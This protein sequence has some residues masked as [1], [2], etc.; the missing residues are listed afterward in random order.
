MRLPSF[1]TASLYGGAALLVGVFF[2]FGCSGCGKDVKRLNGGGATF[3]DPIM[4]KWSAVYKEQKGVEI[5]YKKSGSGNGIQQMI[6]KTIDFGCTDAPMNAEQLDTAKKEGGDVIHVPVIVGS[7]AVIYNLPEAGDRQLILSGKVIAKIYQGIADGDG[8]KAVRWNDPEI[9]ALNPGVNFPNKEIVPVYRS[10]SSGTTKIFTEYLSKSSTEFAQK[11]GSS[12]EPKWPK[13]GS[14]QNGNDGV[15]R[16]VKESANAIGYVELFYAQKNEIRF[17]KV[18]NRKG[19]D[20]S[21][22]QEGVVSA[23]AAAALSTPQDKAPYTLHELTFSLTDTDGDQSYPICGMS[24]AILYMKQPEAK[25][26]KLVE[27][28]KWATSEGQKFAKDLGYAPLPAELTQKIQARL[29][30]V[31]YE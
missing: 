24:Y 9:L 31:Q 6:A 21:P 7:V 23:A 15:A 11:I 29:D 30:Q 26:K 25:G 18:R 2:V 5:D 10:E 19:I 16:Q 28:L 14:G 4:Q 12:T 17:V 20:I 8:V 1:M 13:L 3:V 27:F 22:D